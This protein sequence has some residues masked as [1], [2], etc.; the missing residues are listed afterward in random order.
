MSA[1]IPR[2]AR[3]RSG[4]AGQF[5]VHC[6]SVSLDYCFEHGPC[7]LIEEITPLTSSLRAK[8]RSQRRSAPW[9]GRHR[10]LPVCVVRVDS[11]GGVSPTARDRVFTRMLSVNDHVRDMSPGVDGSAHHRKGLGTPLPAHLKGPLGHLPAYSWNK[12]GKKYQL[13]STATT[14]D[15]GPV[16]SHD[17]LGIGGLCVMMKHGRANQFN[18]G[19]EAA[20]RSS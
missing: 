7:A 4:F 10:L 14:K 1:P 9:R 12:H 8:S 15:L 2:D 18:A 13:C 19:L 6:L 17:V 5:K 20:H 3:L 11:S 16:A